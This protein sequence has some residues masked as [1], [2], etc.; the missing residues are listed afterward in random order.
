MTMTETKTIRTL[1]R[2]YLGCATATL[3]GSIW[4]CAFSFG[5]YDGRAKEI[6][7]QAQ[8]YLQ[9][10]ANLQR[11]C[12]LE[13]SLDV[14][15]EQMLERMHSATPDRESGSEMLYNE[16]ISDPATRQQQRIYNAIQQRAEETKE[17]R[18]YRL[19]LLFGGVTA[20]G[21]LFCFYTWLMQYYKQKEKINSQEL[22]LRSGKI[23][24][25]VPEEENL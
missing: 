21:F 17:E 13:T 10:H 5:R 18:D 14:G 6:E 23:Q 2:I 3:L 9:E 11:L 1:K 22:L 12:T 16:L 19:S 8:L 20:E 25:I 7:T 15:L 24:V 4:A